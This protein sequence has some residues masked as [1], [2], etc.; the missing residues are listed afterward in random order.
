MGKAELGKCEVVSWEEL[1]NSNLIQIEALIRVLE[2]K[3]IINSIEY[4]NEVKL[5][6]DEVQKLIKA[7]SQQN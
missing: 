3:G 1:I 6:N 7:K 2:K 4:L 5:V